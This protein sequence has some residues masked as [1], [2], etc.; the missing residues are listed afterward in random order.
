[1]LVSGST[2]KFAGVPQAT[3]KACAKFSTPPWR[4]LIL[5]SPVPTA[6]TFPP[7][8]VL[9]LLL[10]ASPIPPVVLIAA[11]PATL[12]AALLATPTAALLATPTAVPLAT[13]IAAPLA[14]PITAPPAIL[15]A[16]PATPPGPQS[17]NYDQLLRS[18]EQ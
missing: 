3:V 7:A 1:M 17:S 2:S 10:A 6:S 4:K 12:T 18:R 9:T 13:L 5:Q 11:P 8:T 16:A 14:T 15:T